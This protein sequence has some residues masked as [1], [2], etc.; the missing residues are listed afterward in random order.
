[1]II[2]NARGSCGCTVPEWPK[3]AI[4]P[5]E[6]GKIDVE[7]DSKGKGGQQ[8]K[9]VTLNANIDKEFEIL[10]VKGNVIKEDQQK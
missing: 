6:G 9:T 3:E 7:F 5:G 4:A 2:T 1:M 10:Y 8:N